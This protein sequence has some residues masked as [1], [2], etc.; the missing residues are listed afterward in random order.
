MPPSSLVQRL[1]MIK[2]FPIIKTK[3]ELRECHNEYQKYESMIPG[4]PLIKMVQDCWCSPVSTNGDCGNVFSSQRTTG[5][6]EKACFFSSVKCL[7]VTESLQNH[8]L[9]RI[10][11]CITIS[12]FLLRPTTVVRRTIRLS[13]LTT[14]QKWKIGTDK[15]WWTFF[16]LPSTNF[17]LADFR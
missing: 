11:Q 17:S 13:L 10:S 7:S 16:S 5:R 1:N 9:K 2:L 14:L 12:L 6:K 15:F 4:N 8:H 3:P